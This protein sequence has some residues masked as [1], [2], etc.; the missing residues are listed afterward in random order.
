MNK[1]QYFDNTA[2]MSALEIRYSVDTKGSL[3]RGDGITKKKHDANA[4]VSTSY[5][6]MAVKAN[7]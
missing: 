2:S 7:E 3:D 6:K 5:L 1:N 4:R